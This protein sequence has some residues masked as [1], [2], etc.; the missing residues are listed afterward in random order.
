MSSF[1]SFS[2]TVL[3]RMKN[4]FLENTAY[5]ELTCIEDNE[6]CCA[7]SFAAKTESF[8]AFIWKTL[9]AA[10]VTMGFLPNF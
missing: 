6:F 9:C 1:V 3:F 4:S 5:D 8:F 10:R 7:I 2:G